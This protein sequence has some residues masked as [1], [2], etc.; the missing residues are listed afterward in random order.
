MIQT[1]KWVALVAGAMLGSSALA[2]DQLTDMLE[3]LLALDIEPAAGFAAK[4]IVPPGEMYD[5]LVM[6]EKQ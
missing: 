6:R 1:V 4:V 3:R 2:K 5:P